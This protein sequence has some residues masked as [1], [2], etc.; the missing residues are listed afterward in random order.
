MECSL[1]FRFRAKLSP[2]QFLLPSSPLVRPIR[3]HSPLPSDQWQSM[4]HPP[5]FAPQVRRRTVGFENLV[6]AHSNA[7][8]SQANFDHDRGRFREPLEYPGKHTHLATPLP[9]VVECLVWAIGFWRAVPPHAIDIYKY[10]FVRNAPVIDAKTA[11]ALRKFG[12]SENS[13]KD[14]FPEKR[15]HARICASVS[16]NRLNI[17]DIS[18]QKPNHGNYPK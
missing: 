9:A 10:N 2:G 3:R 16:Q 12:G 18:L 8:R 17:I 5:L 15:P 13:P 1:A 7:E 14:C 4:A 11:M 6:Q